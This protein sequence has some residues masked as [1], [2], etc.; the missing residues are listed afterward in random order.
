MNAYANK[1]LAKNRKKAE[2][3]ERKLQKEKR[4]QA[5]KWKEENKTIPELI[6]SAERAVNGFVKVRDH[7]KPCISCD[8]VIDD[9]GLVTWSR[10][11]AGHF[12]SVGSAPHLRFNTKNIMLQCSRCNIQ[13]SGN[14]IEY[15]IRLVALKGEDYVLA[16]EHDNRPRH[17]TKDDLR[18]IAKIFRARKRLYE[19]LK[20]L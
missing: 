15:R 4:A 7:G 8:A 16:L 17:Y 11:H 9:A 3:Q 6:K 1:A 2:Q 19:R 14:H 12:R 20:G 5:R 10:G 13:L 18:R